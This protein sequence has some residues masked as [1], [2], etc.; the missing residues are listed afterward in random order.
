M[1][2]EGN[3]DMARPRA[4]GKAKTRQPRPR[5]RP[6]RVRRLFS[7]L[8]LLSAAACPAF[9]AETGANAVAEAAPTPSAVDGAIL[10]LVEGVTEF[11]PVSSTGHLIIAGEQLGL[12]SAAPV[13][14][15]GRE[16]PVPFKQAAD[17]FIVIIQIGAIAAVA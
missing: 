2:K 8:L 11:L 10:G 3:G 13:A 14:V 16:E 12:D 4:G 6:C 17:A 5:M 9:S 15:P 7:F 1:G